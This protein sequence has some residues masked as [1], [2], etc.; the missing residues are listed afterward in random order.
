MAF[1]GAR[2]FSLRPRRPGLRCRRGFGQTT[3]RYAFRAQREHRRPGGRLFIRSVPVHWRRLHCFL[4]LWNWVVPPP[5]SP[6][7]LPPLDYCRRTQLRLRGMTSTFKC[8]PR[9]DRG[10]AS[11]TAFTS[12]QPPCKP[13]QGSFPS[14]AAAQN[15]GPAPRLQSPFVSN[16][17][18]F[19][20]NPAANY[21]M[22]A[23]RCPRGG[24]SSPGGGRPCPGATGGGIAPS[25]G[26]ARCR[27]YC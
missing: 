9:H 8:Y 19:V 25:A 20:S 11:D 27:I 14:H 12:L 16:P 23:G 21:S 24:A 18:Q 13:L 2:P 5:R 10:G 26:R 3:T 17:L 15:P 7:G 22:P 6:S 1:R 4:L